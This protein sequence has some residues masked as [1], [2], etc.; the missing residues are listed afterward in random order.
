MYC[1]VGFRNRILGNY[2]ITAIRTPEQVI[3]GDMVY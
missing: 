2:V 1:E 3:T